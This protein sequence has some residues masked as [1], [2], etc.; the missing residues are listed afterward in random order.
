[1]FL[2]L[3]IGVSGIFQSEL[4]GIQSYFFHVRDPNLNAILY[5]PNSTSCDFYYQRKNFLKFLIY[6]FLWLIFGTIVL[7]SSENWSWTVSFYFSVA[8]TSTVG[9]GD[10]PVRNNFTKLFLSFYIIVS[11]ILGAFTF[12]YFNASLE[13]IQIIEQVEKKVLSLQSLDFLLDLNTTSSLSPSHY[14]TDLSNDGSN[15][16]N[17][18]LSSNT[19]NKYQL[20]L[21]ILV[22]QGILDKSRDID[23]ILQK[24]F[25]NE[26]KNITKNHLRVFIDN[27]LENNRRKYRLIQML[28]KKNFLNFIFERQK[29]GLNS[30]SSYS[31]KKDLSNNLSNHLHSSSSSAEDEFN[32]LLSKN[33]IN[34]LEPTHL[35]RTVSSKTS[36]DKIPFI[37]KS[38]DIEGGWKN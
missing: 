19:I 11:S 28:K 13:E 20:V 35:E 25:F 33:S 31:D 6:I 2:V 32:Y 7:K 5:D 1:M 36:Q 10:I 38:L 9:Y 29:W 27:E 37:S 22:H 15:S 23:P 8:T 16:N 3:F 24:L 14:H 21:E 30:I 18:D 12:R 26:E 17:S 34:I 4:G